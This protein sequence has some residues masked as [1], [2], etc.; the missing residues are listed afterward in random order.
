MFK[1]VMDDK[2]RGVVSYVIVDQYTPAFGFVVCSV[3][4]SQYGSECVC[5]W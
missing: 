4:P 2:E 5:I 1:T 3:A